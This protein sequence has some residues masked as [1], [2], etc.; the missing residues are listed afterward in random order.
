MTLGD[1]TARLPDLSDV[2]DAPDRVLRTLGLERRTSVATAPS[3]WL[4]FGLGIAI[5]V[6]LAVLLR[7]RDGL[8]I[9]EPEEEEL[10]AH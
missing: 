6:G 7:A 5:G 2:R 10:Q 4:A 1:V 8:E 9:A 3:V